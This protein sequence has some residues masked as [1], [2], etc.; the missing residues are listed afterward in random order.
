MRP[1]RSLKAFDALRERN[2]RILWISTVVTSGAMQMET[3]VL[4]WYIL[5]VTGSPF[6]VGLLT[7]FRTGATMFGT[8]A[9]TLAD[10]MSRKGLVMADQIIMVLVAAIMIV[11]LV[12]KTI[13][14]WHVFAGAAVTGLAR[15]FDQP[16]RQALM[17]DSVGPEKLTNA[18]GLNLVGMN[19][20]WAVGPLLAGAIYAM[21]GP[22]GGYTALLLCYLL[23]AVFL[24]FV[25]IKGS[26]QRVTD[27]SMWRTMWTGVTYIRGK[28][29][30]ISALIM[31]GIANLTAFPFLF[32]LMPVYA[33]KTLGTDSTGFGLLLSAVGVGTIIGALVVTVQPDMRHM[34]RLMALAMFLWHLSCVAVVFTDSL[35]LA[36]PLIVFNGA[37]QS[38]SMATIQTLLLGTAAPEYRGRVLGLRSLAV[39]P[40]PIGSTIVGWMIGLNGV[41]AT[42]LTTAL[43][44]S[45]LVWG[46]VLALPV[47]WKVL[48][49]QAQP[50]AQALPK[51]T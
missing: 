1:F 32:T 47:T 39:Y 8:V 41:P 29:L 10:R 51:A 21:A 45:L 17:A 34:G 6:L 23:S 42:T 13:Q 16:A 48:R 44:G 43:F 50:P 5:Q 3:V 30:L 27:E 18:I 2:Y 12:T 28:G 40:L 4:S 25:R 26:S 36:L 38:I 11:L 33:E 24:I 15:V 22:E 35:A 37:M 9:G 14:P 49:S 7:A 20:M 46:T 19:A 31:A